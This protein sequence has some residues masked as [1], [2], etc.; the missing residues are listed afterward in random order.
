[1]ITH[2]VTRAMAAAGLVVTAFVTAPAALA[3]SN[4]S[5]KGRME[6]YGF[7]MLDMGYDSGQNDPD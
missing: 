1:M 4:D 2:A 3:Q 7:A 5:S 6:I